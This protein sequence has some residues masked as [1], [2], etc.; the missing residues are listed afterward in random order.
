MANLAGAM[1][2]ER[3]APATCRDRTSEF[4]AIAERLSKQ[5]G[6]VGAAH[7]GLWP[8]PQASVGTGAGLR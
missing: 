6:K 3:M 8:S 7:P 1:G 2:M 4:L 5:Q